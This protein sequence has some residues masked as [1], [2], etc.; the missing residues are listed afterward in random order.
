ML[1]GIFD[2]L[3]LLATHDHHSGL[4]ALGFLGTA[5]LGFGLFG[6]AGYVVGAV[7]GAAGAGARRPAAP[8]LRRDVR[9]A[10]PPGSADADADLDRTVIPCPTSGFLIPA[11]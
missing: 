11:I 1:V 5:A 2:G 7:E 6:A 3:A 4:T 8:C 10:L 9:S